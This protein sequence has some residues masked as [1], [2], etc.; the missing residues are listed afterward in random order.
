MWILFQNGDDALY[1]AARQ[2][3][4]DIVQFL[5]EQGAE[6]NNQNKVHISVYSNL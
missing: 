4:V 2:G 3:H 6:I 1:T 5:K